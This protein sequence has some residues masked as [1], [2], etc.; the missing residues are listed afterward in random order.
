MERLLRLASRV[1]IN[2]QVNFVM[3]MSDEGEGSID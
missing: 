1:D 2:E 3:R